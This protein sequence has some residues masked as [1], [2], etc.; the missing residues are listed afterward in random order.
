MTVEQTDFAIEISRALIWQ[1]DSAPK[2]R[3]MIEDKQKWVDENVVQFW[4][5]WYRDVYDMRTI[6]DFG[7]QVWAIILGMNFT[8]QS[9][10]PTVWFGF[11]GSGGVSFNQAGFYPSGKLALTTEQKRYILQLRYRQ[12]ISG[13]TISD[14]NNAVQVMLPG[15][16]VLDQLDMNIMITYPTIPT[17]PQQFIL[18]N[19]DVIPRPAGVK[20]NRRFG[21][22]TWFGFTG[23]GGQNFNNSNFG[24]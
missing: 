17:A 5:N 16:K 13:G 7:C 23:S 9:E 1:Y 11:T 3:A 2:I 21:Y 4:E 22:S 10:V 19:Y 12:L 18:D 24:G 15:A 8:L 6:N 20:I 14:I